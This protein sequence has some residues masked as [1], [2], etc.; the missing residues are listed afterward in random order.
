MTTEAQYHK[1]VIHR[2]TGEHYDQNYDPVAQMVKDRYTRARE[3]R[4][5]D[6]IGRYS[7]EESLVNCYNQYHSI[8]EPCDA[9]LE[10]RINTNVHMSLTK[11]KVDTLVAW[12]RDLIGST[13]N[14]PFIVEPTPIPDLNE[15]AKQQVIMKM[16]A[17]MLAGF[18]GTPEQ[19]F[20]LARQLKA[21]QLAEEF[22]L[23]NIASQGMQK[24]IDDQLIEAGF[25]NQMM[26]FLTNFALYPY[27]VMIGP[28][29][30]MIPVFKWRGN[31][32][33]TGTKTILSAYN[34]S[35]FDYYWSPDTYQ[36]G[37]GTCDIIRIR[38]TKMNLLRCVDLPGF[39]R[40]NIINAV[41]YFDHP[42]H[43]LD[44]LSQN[45]DKDRMP[46]KNWPQDTSIDLL[47]H[48]GALSGR[49]LRNY[50]MTG[51][52]D[53]K[54]YECQAMT[55]GSWTIRLMLNPNPDMSA[56]PIYSASYQRVPG[57]MAGYGIG[58]IIRDI[59]R[60]YMAA[61][62][63][64]IENIGFSTAPIG[65]VDYARIQR[66]MSD[67]Q[68][69]QLMSATV[70]PT[71]PDMA[72][73]G[74]PAHYFHN[75]PNISG[76]LVNVMQYFTEL[77]DRHTGIPAAMSGQPV[78]TGVNR[79]FRGI[80]ALYGNA[81]KGV[82]SAL[83]NL[84][85]ELFEP[86]GKNYFAYNMKFSKDQTIKGDSMV[87]ARG[88]EGLLQKEIDKQN[89]LENLQMIAQLSQT[90]QV[91]PKVLNWAVTKA[92][93]TSGVP[94][95]ELGVDDQAE[96]PAHPDQMAQAIGQVPPSPPEALPQ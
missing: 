24:L 62:R 87:R 43:S 41:Q 25:R 95:A 93:Q 61:Y 48:Y 31:S 20:E 92:L 26:D 16:R 66:Y 49:E 9:E 55:L 6:K 37:K 78:G 8:P 28:M 50:G 34:V 76:Q 22:R 79:T 29:P 2:K 88:M 36:A 90:G 72:G 27:A 94:L 3:W 59:E 77:A 44:W 40:Q 89:S 86:L 81:L 5:S 46:I 1:Q 85:K 54:F 15:S 11:H 14:S 42:D 17:K 33:T 52:E 30:E 74:R 73:G 64:L 4:R 70:I 83:I 60:S 71:D 68:L 21:E 67:D 65:E 18:E 58:Q 63:G 75:V 82:Q 45:P 12:L 84:D 7:V 38:M 13:N 51:V 19:V 47:V 69:G 80:M 10:E 91:D 53:T 32:P 35:P 57:K 96:M 23:A 56:R 39:I